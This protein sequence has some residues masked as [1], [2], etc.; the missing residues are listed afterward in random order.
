MSATFLL[1]P[2]N[3]VRLVGVGRQEVTTRGGVVHYEGGLVPAPNRLAHVEPLRAARSVPG[4]LGL[5]GVDFVHDATGG[6]TTVIEINPRPTTS[7]VGLRHLLAP[8]AIAR[9][10]IDAVTG[11]QPALDLRGMIP[12]DISAW[13]R[14]FPDGTVSELPRSPDEPA[15]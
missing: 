11:N 10:W 2:G 3:S 6:T 4:L 5:V 13:V 8:G 15:F 1:G 9:A 12:P 14:F 7:L